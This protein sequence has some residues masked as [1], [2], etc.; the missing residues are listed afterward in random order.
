MMMICGSSSYQP[1]INFKTTLDSDATLLHSGK[2]I[3]T[4]QPQT[5]NVIT[6]GVKMNAQHSNTLSLSL[7]PLSPPS[8]LCWEVLEVCVDPY[9]QLSTNYIF[10]LA[11]RLLFPAFQRELRNRSFVLI[12]II[13]TLPES[14]FRPCSCE[15]QVAG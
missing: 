2:L 6:I 1:L 8:A 12:I 14:Y 10:S 7:S 15:A 9:L 13:I 5:K 3:R 11:P 4:G